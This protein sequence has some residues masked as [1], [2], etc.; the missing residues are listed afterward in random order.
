[1]TKPPDVK[2]VLKNTPFSVVIQ[3]VGRI[4]GY[5]FYRTSDWPYPDSKP[6]VHELLGTDI[7][8]H[9][10]AYNFALGLSLGYA[11]RKLIIRKEG[12]LDHATSR[13]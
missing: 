8:G 13:L 1:M 3:K 4:T 9:T 7:D 5:K 2:K 12:D 6:E 10:N 11:Q